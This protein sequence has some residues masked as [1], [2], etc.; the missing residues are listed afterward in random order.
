[1]PFAF[2]GVSTLSID[3]AIQWTNRT[4]DEHP[5]EV[6]DVIGRKLWSWSPNKEPI[7]RAIADSLFDDEPQTFSA[8]WMPENGSRVLH[9]RATVFPLPR[10]RTHDLVLLWADAHSGHPL[11]KA[12][13][14]TLRCFAD[15]MTQPET[16][17]HLGVTVAT[18]KTALMHAREKLGARN[19]THAVSLAERRG[20]I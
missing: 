2:G 18:V 16:A 12:E 15:G 10:G 17:R 19:V 4:A 11:T 6:D 20:L 9:T 1:M 7:R 13:T 5:V 8:G 14:R 3:G